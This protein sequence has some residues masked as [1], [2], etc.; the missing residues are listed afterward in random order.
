MKGFDCYC[1]DMKLYLNPFDRSNV[2]A[3][4]ENRF[5]RFDAQNCVENSVQHV[6][7]GANDG[8]DDG[9]DDDDG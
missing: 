8:D 9:G 2:G 3:E 5:D 6:L 7:N 1:R 4:R